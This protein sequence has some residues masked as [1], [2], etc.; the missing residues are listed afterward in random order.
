MLAARSVALVGAS[1][2]PGSFG[3]RMIIEARRSSARMHLVNPRYDQIDGVACAP[4]LAALDEP[5][6]LVLLGVPDA[7]LLDELKAAAA[8]GAR[9]AVIFGSAHGAALRSAVTATATEAG[10][11]V[12]GAGCMGFVNNA[13]GLRAL[14]YLEPDPLPPGGVSLVTHSGSAF[15]TLLRSGRGFGFR[16]AVSSGQELVTDTADYVDYILE[17][18]GTSLIALLLETPRSVGRLRSGLRRAAQRGIPVVL[19]PV[20]HSPRGRAMV[21]AHSGALAGDAAGWQAFCADTGAVRVSDMAEFVDTIELFETGRRRR[22]EAHGIATVHDSGAERALCADV[23]HDLDV[24]FAELT[25]PTLTAIGELLDDGLAPGNPLDVWGTGA[26]TRELFGGCLR[27]LAADPGVAVTALAVDLVTEFDDD[28]A[29][30][31]AILDIA[32][33]TDA[34]LAVLTSVPSAIDAPTAR[35]LRANRIAVL[36]GARSGIAAL[37][38]LAHW[39]LPVSAA[40]PR[41]DDARAQRWAARLAEPGW[42]SPSAFALLADYGVAVTRSRTAHSV[43]EALSAA[44]TVGYPVAVKTLG[45]AHKSDVGGV[46]LNIADPGALR[47]AYEEMAAR[48]GSGVSID[49][50]APTGVEISLGVVRDDN[51][52][53]LVVVAAGGTLVELLADRAVA[54][55][56][57][58]RET[59]AG[60]LRSLNTAPLLAGWRGA[61]PVDMAALT[62]AVVGFSQLAIE[63]GDHLD[64]VEA[65][66][67]I[68]SAAGVVAVDALVIPRAR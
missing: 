3:E 58:S 2:R 1:P 25:D 24:E 60:L 22:P 36:E 5:I 7:A 52:G 14:G 18:P 20:G 65:N 10:M 68:A 62:D 35:R 57:V 53:P 12:C 17:D 63:L 11:A 45:S 26:D 48:L 16:L 4:S 67:V 59:A 44:A 27:A 32:A 28:T 15:S 49:A 54:C 56:P 34:P 23:A 55:P 30:A 42:D 41:I 47:T 29:Y 19:L 9:S 37:G 66:P 8:I 43:A 51:F 13:T 50:M 21:A 31:D 38:H 33:D 6:D 64:A 40:T 61:P 39:P 46:V